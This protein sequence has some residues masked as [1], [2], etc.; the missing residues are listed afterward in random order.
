MATS[1][2]YSSQTACAWPWGG[3]RGRKDCCSS[4]LVSWDS[5]SHAALLKSITSLLRK[6]GKA[7]VY[8]VSGLH[9]G[10]AKIV[11][12]LR[13]ARR[14]GLLLTDFPPP[15]PGQQWPLL[16]RAEGEVQ[17]QETAA[18]AHD[19]TLARAPTQL[20]EMQVL[21]DKSEEAVLHTDTRI[22]QAKTTR[23]N[24]MRRAFV[25]EEREEEKKENNGVHVRNTWITFAALAWQT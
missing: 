20:L 3:M 18:Y 8:M 17:A 14:L 21:T 24:G 11:S 25:V 23:L 9:T 10:R 12:F 1:T 15:S 6:D 4:V 16:T 22:W 13:R 7:R 5:L 19:D 2:S